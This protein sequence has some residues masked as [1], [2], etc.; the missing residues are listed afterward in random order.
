MWGHWE[1]PCWGDGMELG[2]VPAEEG[3]RGRFFPSFLPQMNRGVRGSVDRHRDSANLYQVNP[4][5][6]TC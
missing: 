3:K 4:S 1:Q 2:E 6:K 5:L